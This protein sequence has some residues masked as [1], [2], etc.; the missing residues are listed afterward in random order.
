MFVWIVPSFFYSTILTFLSSV[1]LQNNR[2][3]SKYRWIVCKSTKLNLLHFLSSLLKAILYLEFE[4]NSPKNAVT[5]TKII[6]NIVEFKSNSLN[7]YKESNNLN[8]NSLNSTFLMFTITNNTEVEW[9]KNLTE[10]FFSKIQTITG[11][12]IAWSIFS[13]SFKNLSL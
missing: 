3:I 7:V 13:C 8:K 9:K 10:H 1:I 6:I 2:I 12:E 5:M 11:I 4:F